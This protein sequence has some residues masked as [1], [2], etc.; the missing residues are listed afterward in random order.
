MQYVPV[1]AVLEMSAIFS[2]VFFALIAIGAVYHYSQDVRFRRWAISMVLFWIA[3]LP[4]NIFVGFTFL[5]D[6][7][8]S[9]LRVFGTFM[10][11]RAFGFKPLSKLS[12]AKLH[13]SIFLFLALYWFAIILLGLPNSTS[14]ILCSTLMV[15]AFFYAGNEILNFTHNRT[16]VWLS[17]G[18][19]Y[20]LWA[21]FSIPM[22]LL[23]FIPEVVIFGYLQFMA[24]CLVLVTMFLAFFGSITRRLERNL[25][26]TEMTGSLISHDLRNF[27]NVTYGALDLVE[28]K[29]AESED[30]LQTAKGTIEDA[31]EFIKDVRTML[32]E[33]GT[34]ST[35]MEDLDLTILVNKVIDRAKLEHGL[36]EKQVRITTDDI[37]FACTSPLMAQVVWNIIDNGIRH[38]PDSPEIQISIQE[39]SRVVVSISDCSGGI[40][41]D[42]KE[43]LLGSRKNGDGLGLGLMLI[44]EISNVCSV[45]LRIEDRLEGDSVIGTVYHL[46]FP[47]SGGIPA[48]H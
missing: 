42:I 16:K 30:M 29:D 41:E 34:Y 43:K 9:L 37:I 31:S 40:D 14:A 32:I 45:V 39:Q 5:G 13:T 26:L 12:N 27:L 18:V 48:N 15:L 46:E 36:T 47:T 11:L 28:T 4:P 10:V 6:F 24:Q 17:A 7:I 25:K 33:I 38:A 20:I 22:I 35:S 1:E 44:R 21:I 19:S 2:G 23:P 8:S 3:F